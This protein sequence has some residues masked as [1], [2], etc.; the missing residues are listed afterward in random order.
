MFFFF[1]KLQKK[2]TRFYFWQPFF[3]A[4]F[5]FCLN[6]LANKISRIE[7]TTDSERSCL[8][9]ALLNGFAPVPQAKQLVST[10]GKKLMAIDGWRHRYDSL[11]VLY[12]DLADEERQQKK[13]RFTIKKERKK[14]GVMFLTLR[15]SCIN[16]HSLWELSCQSWTELSAPWVCSEKT[17]CYAFKY[18][19]SISYLTWFYT[20]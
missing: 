8:W 9:S 5:F 12:L 6:K 17:M 11:F 18:V 1:H 16:G 13:R 3:R 7:E 20:T 19:C 10:H 2:L 15:P 14:N 4:F